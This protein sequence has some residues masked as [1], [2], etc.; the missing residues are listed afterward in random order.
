MLKSNKLGKIDK[1]GADE[2][3]RRFEMSSIEVIEQH[4]LANG[5]TVKVTKLGK[6]YNFVRLFLEDQPPYIEM[7]LNLKRALSLLAGA[8]QQDVLD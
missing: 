5:D 7:G 1:V 2:G 4:H 6:Q 8:I 3:N